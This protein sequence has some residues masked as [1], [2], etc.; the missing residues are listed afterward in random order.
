MSFRLGLV[1]IV[2]CTAAVLAM[3]SCSM[4]EDKNIA[5]AAVKL[6]HTQLGS[7]QIHEIYIGTSDEFRKA[8]TEAQFTEFLSAVKRKLGSVKS[9]TPMGWRVNYVPMGT[10]VNLEYQ[11]EFDDGPATE[12]FSWRIKGKH[13]ELMGYNINSAALIT[14]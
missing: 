12:S 6:F 9:S 10:I 13:A 1:T 14:K 4:S 11:T 3:T 8:S 7:E 5:D 2:I